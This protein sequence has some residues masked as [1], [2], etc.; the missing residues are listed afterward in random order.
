MTKTKLIAVVIMIMLPAPIMQ[1]DAV[2]PLNIKYFYGLKEGNYLK[3]HL[4]F[5]DN[6]AHDSITHLTIV[7]SIET[8]LYGVLYN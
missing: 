4:A 7:D 3:F 2:E 6:K 5:N 8:I 1:L